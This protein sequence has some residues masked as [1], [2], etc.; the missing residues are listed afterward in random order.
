MS[1]H[2][3][4]PF[5]CAVATVLVVLGCQKLA[6][7]RPPSVDYTASEFS[8]TGPDKLP[9]GLISIRL[10]NNGHEPH[11]GQ[12][13]RLNDGVS[14]DQFMSAL[15]YD[16]QQAAALVSIEGGPGLIDPQAT[17]EVSLELAPGTYLL[18]CFV[19]SEDGVPHLAKG[20]LKPL[21]VASASGPALPEPAVAA[22]FTARDFQFEM[23]AELP[24]GRATYRV[25]NLGPQPH[26]VG[27]IKLAPGA[28]V[29]DVLAFYTGEPSGPPPFQSVGG[30]NGLGAGKSGF[31]T[32]DLQPGQYAAVC[33]IPD[34]SSG[35]SHVDLGMIRPFV[36]K[37]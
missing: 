7:P 14:L 1:P 37:G 33:L 30:I 8:F 6:A 31:M 12:L 23:P 28:S 35:H 18:A 26:E 4:L 24:Y 13:L 36:V 9:A 32:L 20:M 10:T 21:Q 2:R 3:L 29:Q 22:T 15:Q 27:I 19:P 25:T 16:E 5:L 17:A 34:P 11:H